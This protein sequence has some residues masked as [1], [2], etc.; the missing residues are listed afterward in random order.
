MKKQEFLDELKG[1]LAVLEDE[2]QE[3]ILGEYSQ[4]I[5]MKIEK[6]MSEDEAIRDFGSLQ[7]LA[8][9]ILEAYHVKPGY[10]RA[11]T[12]RAFPRLFGKW[13]DR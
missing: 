3:D 11:G 13:A 7:E 6:G 5:Q 9:E 12:G 8:A 4:H 2:E 1:Y 10:G